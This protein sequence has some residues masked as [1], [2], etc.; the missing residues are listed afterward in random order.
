[1]TDFVSQ[2]IKTYF[3]HEILS[4]TWNYFVQLEY[5]INAVVPRESS[6]GL[7]LDLVAHFDVV[8]CYAFSPLFMF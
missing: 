5:R 3:Q 2:C 8:Y 1:M 4:R 7:E 6:V